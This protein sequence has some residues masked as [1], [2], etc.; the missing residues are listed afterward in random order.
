MRC[1][2]SLSGCLAG[3][4]SGNER[5]VRR[6]TRWSRPSHAPHGRL[7]AKGRRPLCGTTGVLPVALNPA[8][9]CDGAAMA[10]QRD[11]AEDPGKSERCNG[12]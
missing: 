4:A 5:A 2:S 6:I 1:E 7:I 8:Q 9:D 12:G 11:S 3:P 10:R